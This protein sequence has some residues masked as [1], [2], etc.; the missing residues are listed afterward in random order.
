MS[1]EAALHELRNAISSLNVYR[2][3]FRTI[4]VHSFADKLGYVTVRSSNSNSDDFTNCKVHYT[5]AFWVDESAIRSD[6]QFSCR[7]LPG[8]KGT[9]LDL[10]TL[11]LCSRVDFDLQAPGYVFNLTGLIFPETVRGG[12][13]F[14]LYFTE[15]AFAPQHGIYLPKYS[16]GTSFT[17]DWIGGREISSAYKTPVKCPEN[18]KWSPIYLHRLY[19][20]AETMVGVFENLADVSGESGTYKILVGSINL[21]L[22]TQEQKN[23][24]INKG[25]ILS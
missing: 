25:W 20:T 14:H 9:Y 15:K 12:S 18:T 1:I 11:G 24:A 16:E 10:S 3:P 4:Y 13:K 22:L 17:S 8:I 7:I 6:G 5:R 23:I 19:M 2:N 21:G